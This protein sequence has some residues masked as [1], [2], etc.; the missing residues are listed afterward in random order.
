LGFP[1]EWNRNPLTGRIDFARRQWT[2]VNEG[3]TGDI[4]GLW[5]PSRFSLA[6]RLARL[7]AVT[8]DER[9]PEVFWQLFD[10]W[11]AANPPNAGPQWLSSQEVALRALAWIFGLRAFVR[12]PA[13]SATRV[14]KV[15]A[16]LDAHARRIEATLAYAKSQNNNHLI[17]EGC[18]LFTIGLLFPA[19]PKA[20]RWRALGRALLEGTSVQFF[21]DGG[22]IQHSINYHR[23][24]LQL[25]LWALRLG[26]IHGQPFSERLYDCVDRSLELLSAIVDP[27]TGRMPNFGHNDGA[28][29]LP[30]NDCEYEDYRPLLQ[31]LSLWRKGA[32]IWT[33]GSWDEDAIWIL[34]PDA[35]DCVAR[36]SPEESERTKKNLSAPNAGVYVIQGKESRAVI[37]CAQFHERPAHA[38]QLNIDLWWRGENIACDAGSYLYGGDPPWRNSLTHAAVHN[39]VTID[40]LDQM[41][42]SGRFGWATLAQAQGKFLGDAKWEGL[43]NGYS[44]LGVTHRRTVE[45]VNENMWVVTDDLIGS[46][47]HTVRLH[48]LI[49]DYPWEWNDLRKDLALGELISE[50]MT[51]WKQ[52]S[53]VGLI[54]RTPAGGF[55]LRIWS[56]RPALWDLYRAGE[57]IH[58]DD[59]QDRTVPEA[60]RGWHSL[61]YASK[62]PALSLAGWTQ[63]I[64]PVRFISVWIPLPCGG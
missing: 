60:I 47:A 21:H 16:A 11:L 23:L 45:R 62:I 2:K 41:K 5:E 63:G 42:Q 48:W 54:L 27:E 40:G 32:R 4:K 18:G 14:T 26:E 57:K 24:A 19:L 10:S 43:H 8:R 51:G 38:D 3:A 59:T 15:I 37:R 61:R 53:G 46:G 36:L 29:F 17:S 20:A 28:L 30:L 13:T 9:A 6:F 33:A 1:P 56:S 12:S 34:G 31:G 44:A 64:G 39:T 50:K 22:Y 35:V 58:G 25:Y 52:G 7:Y 55:S 49:P